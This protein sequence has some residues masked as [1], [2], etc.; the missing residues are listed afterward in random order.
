MPAGSTFLEFT[1][2]VGLVDLDNNK[3]DPAAR[4]SKWEPYVT[5]VGASDHRLG[6]GVLDSFIFRT[7]YGARFELRNI[8]A[9]KHGDCIR[10]LKWLQDGG[11]VA[12]HTGD[13]TDTTY[14]T[15][16]AA[17]GWDASKA[18]TFAPDG[19][20]LQYTLALDLID[21]SDS[22]VPLAAVYGAYD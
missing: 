4:F 10:L 7:D 1:D 5:E 13:A 2:G 6:S 19:A 14:P 16:G 15:C 12:V 8:P 18:L 20:V 21:V 11:S 3:P 22:P 9:S 17:P